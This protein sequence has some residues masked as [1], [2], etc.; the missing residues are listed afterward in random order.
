VAQLMQRPSAVTRGD[1]GGRPAVD[2]EHGPAS[3]PL[4]QPGR[5]WAG[6]VASAPIRSRRPWG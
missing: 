3:A 1:V 2:E 6:P 5:S 4:E